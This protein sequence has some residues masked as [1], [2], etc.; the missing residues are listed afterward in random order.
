MIAFITWKWGRKYGAADVNRWAR[1]IRR[2]LAPGTQALLICITDDPIDLDLDLDL[3]MPVS[4]DDLPDP[5][6]VRGLLGYKDGC[7]ARLVM[8]SDGFTEMMRIMGVTSVVATDLDCV[9]T[10][11]LSQ[12][13]QTRGFGIAYGIH[14]LECRY[15]G[16]IM[17]F[18][19][20]ARPDFWHNF[21]LELAESVAWGGTRASP[22]R[23]YWGT[24]QS[25]IWF[26]Q[27]LEDTPLTPHGH[28]V[29]GYMKPGWPP[30]TG[31]PENARVV[32]FPGRRDPR[33]PHIRAA[34]PWITEHWQ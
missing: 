3:M 18:E 33:D 5:S 12:I 8:F 17:T 30:G 26:R 29:Y 10:G 19:P 32:F 7:Y 1:S 6:R 23:V 20:G 25:W 34:S 14:Y 24:D 27:R 21:D 22:E 13:A 31:L 4:M 9:V 11:D 28:G 2:R 15:N 16:S